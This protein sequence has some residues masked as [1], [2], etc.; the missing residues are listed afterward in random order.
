MNYKEIMSQVDKKKA[1]QF[2]TLLKANYA[3]SGGN[4]WYNNFTSFV[5][6]NLAN[7]GIVVIHVNSGTANAVVTRMERKSG[8]SL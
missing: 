6:S 1:I 4:D 5:S 8:I 2:M 3:A 7:I